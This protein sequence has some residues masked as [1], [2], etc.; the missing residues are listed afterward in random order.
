MPKNNWTNELVF[1][2]DALKREKARINLLMPYFG[3]AR[4]DRIAERGE[5][6]SAKVI[7]DWLKSFR[8]NRIIVV[9][10]HSPRLRK[11]LG[12]KNIVPYELIYPKARK[13]D[14]IVAPDKGT[15]HFV[16]KV[17][18]A[19]RRP[20]ITML[21]SRPVKEKVR[22]AMKGGDVKGKKVL[23]L[24]DMISTGSTIIEASRKLREKGA[25]EI[26]V[27]ATHG[28]FADGAIRRLERSP[29]KRIYVT[30][31]V[32]R[33]IR[34]RKIKVMDISGFIERTMRK[35]S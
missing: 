13:S 15:I 6:L 35:G 1:L 5:S 4:Q 9:E 2:L 20:F 27:F 24:D 33:R 23:I 26:Y 14:V 31:T 21:K 10:M 19:C 3:Y 17:S 32:P 22:I 18:R 16:K 34:S 12:Y 28:I 8:L 30:N 7:C 29:I 25:K 11:F